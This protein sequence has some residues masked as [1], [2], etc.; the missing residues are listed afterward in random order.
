MK[1]LTKSTYSIIKFQILLVG[2][3]Q[4]LP[5]RPK[6]GGKDFSSSMTCANPPSAPKLTLK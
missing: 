1:R 2:N 3:I 5:T 6:Y 4:K